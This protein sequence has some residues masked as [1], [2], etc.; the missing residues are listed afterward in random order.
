VYSKTLHDPQ[1]TVALK[2]FDRSYFIA[3]GE[4]AHP[5]KVRESARN[6]HGLAGRRLVP[7]LVRIRFLDY[8]S[9]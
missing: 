2:D 9:G 3:S 7:Q 4:V 1:V 6:G 8:V 5:G